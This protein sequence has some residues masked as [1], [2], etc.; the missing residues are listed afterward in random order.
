[1]MRGSSKLLTHYNY[2]IHTELIEDLF[3]NDLHKLRKYPDSQS[4]IGGYVEKVW[5]LIEIIKK[6]YKRYKVTPTDTLVSKILLGVA[7]ATPAYDTYFKDF[8]KSQ[9]ISPKLNRKSLTILWERYLNND[10]FNRKTLRKYTEHPPM[11]IIDMAGFQY[12]NKLKN[13]E[14]EIC[15]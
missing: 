9:G 11:K 12:G 3:K 10:F 15:Q 14:E 2:K 7:G 13:K 6:Y 4:E 5:N 1:M 8:L